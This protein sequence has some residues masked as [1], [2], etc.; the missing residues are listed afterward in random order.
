[1]PTR[2]FA[3]VVVAGG[4]SSGGWKSSPEN[5]SDIQGDLLVAENSED[6]GGVVRVQYDH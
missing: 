3:C 2:K 5:F 4:V 1:M 6:E